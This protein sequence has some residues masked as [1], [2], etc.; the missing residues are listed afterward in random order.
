MTCKPSIRFEQMVT[1]VIA[2][3][4]PPYLNTHDVSGCRCDMVHSLALND[5]P[6]TLRLSSTSGVMQGVFP[7]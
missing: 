4:I 1:K 7:Q 2:Q 3:F 6:L 5:T